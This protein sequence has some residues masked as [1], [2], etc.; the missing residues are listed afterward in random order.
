MKIFAPFLVAALA[1]QSWAV[2]TLYLAGDSTMAL[3]GG[4][5][6]TQGLSTRFLFMAVD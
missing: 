3:G 1:T 6:G 2:P 5:S 4:G